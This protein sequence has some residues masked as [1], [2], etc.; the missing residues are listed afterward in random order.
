MT[1]TDRPEG[2]AIAGERDE[3]VERLVRARRRAAGFRTAARRAI[4]LARRYRTEEGRAGGPREVAC[5][6]QARTWRDEAR[7]V[8]L[9]ASLGQAPRPGLARVRDMADMAAEVLRQIG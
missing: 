9:A 7:R 8:V 6:A 1:T 4:R 3:D 5:L 2:P